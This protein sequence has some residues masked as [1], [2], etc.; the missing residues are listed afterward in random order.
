MDNTQGQKEKVLFVDID[1][2]KHFISEEVVGMYTYFVESWLTP[3]STHLHT[4]TL[5]QT[6]A[7]FI[8]TAH[9]AFHGS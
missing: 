7:T 8:L 2:H 9:L 4:H 6:I 5:P 1:L 3:P